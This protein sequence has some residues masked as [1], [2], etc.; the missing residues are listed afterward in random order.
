MKHVG[1]SSTSSSTNVLKVGDRGSRCNNYH[2]VDILSINKGKKKT[3]YGI[4]AKGMWFKY[5]TFTIKSI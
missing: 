2:L 5:P 1:L 4:I 3:L